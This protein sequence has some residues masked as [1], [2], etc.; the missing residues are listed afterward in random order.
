MAQEGLLTPIEG[1]GAQL[2]QVTSP[3]APPEL[4][5]YELAQEAYYAGAFCYATALE[6][7]RL[8]DQR[9][10]GFRLFLPSSPSGTTVH[11]LSGPDAEAEENESPNLMPP[12]TEAADWRLAPLP[13]YVR[14]TK[15]GDYSIRTHSAK[16]AWLFG[17]ELIEA[18]GVVV[19]VT[20]IE[21]T[22]IDGLRHPKLCGGLS[23][24]F[25]AW[26]RAVEDERASPARLAD[27]AERFGQSI[28]YQRLGFVMET[29]G[30]EHQMLDRWKEEEVMRGGSRLL[31]A[32]Q[33]YASRYD[34]AWAL[35]LN[36]PTAILES[37]DV[38]YS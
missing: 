13:S 3:Y 21:R 35:S 4:N 30:L 7:H 2:Y 17:F 25:R 19:R 15:A 36:H 5:P 8:S 31:S 1:S 24:V 14:L 12:G 20:D 23:E 26:V 10:Q 34:E 32:E 37:R 16:P 29:L 22:L 33:P 11:R 27:Y 18:R 38:A 9:E 28:L 6:L